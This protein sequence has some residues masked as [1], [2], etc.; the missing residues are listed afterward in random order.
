MQASRK[1]SWGL[2]TLGALL[3]TYAL[4][5]E[6]F[7]LGI[8]P[9][10]MPERIALERNQLWILSSWFRYAGHG[11]ALVGLITSVLFKNK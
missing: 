7:T 5:T 2:L 1:I 3:T 6:T 11:L 9:Q 10:D 8:P 4:Y